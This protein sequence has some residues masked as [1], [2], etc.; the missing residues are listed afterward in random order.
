M[1]EVRLFHL[2]GNAELLGNAAMGMRL[3]ETDEAGKFFV[4]QAALYDLQ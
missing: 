3:P 4:S 2:L 1:G